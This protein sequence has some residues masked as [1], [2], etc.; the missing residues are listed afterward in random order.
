MKRILVTGGC[1]FVGRNLIKN[2][3]ADSNNFVVCVDS[4]QQY[5]G[6]KHPKVWPE[7]NPLDYSNFEFIQLDCRTYFANQFD[8][9]DEIFHLAA[10]VGGRLMIENNPL[11]VGEDL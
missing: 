4:L 8:Y 6:C 2:L 11:A 7:F 3:I 9:F 1:G 10:M 5:T